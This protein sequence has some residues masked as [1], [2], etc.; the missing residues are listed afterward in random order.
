MEATK[1]IVIGCDHAGYSAKLAL[2]PYLEEKG[3]SVIDV[4]THSE[5]SCDYP[6]PVHRLCTE[7]QSGT[8]PFGIL[9]CGTGIGVSIAANKHPGIRAALCGDVYSAEMTRQHNDA[10][11]LCMGARVIDLE[12]MRRIIDIF[13]S[14][15]ALS[16]ER[17]KRRVRMIND[18]DAGTFDESKYE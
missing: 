6:I 17:H 11:V 8:V 9:I 16:E 5:A 18:L 12:L 14:T 13:L 1:S 3:Y 15:D 10:N 4:G 2:I 7:L